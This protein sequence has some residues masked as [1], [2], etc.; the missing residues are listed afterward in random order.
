LQKPETFDPLKIGRYTVIHVWYEYPGELRS[1]AKYFIVLRHSQTSKGFICRCIKATCRVSRYES[2][3]DLLKGVVLYEEKT[4]PF[5]SEKTVIDPD[6][7]LD[8]NHAHLSD[9]S[10]KNRFRI[11]GKMPDDFHAKLVTAINQSEQLE[12]K[13]KRDLL[14][15]IGEASTS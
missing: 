7:G 1:E 12:P 6:N 3:P 15:Y 5:F 10:R 11:A 14:D 8:I 4:I 9:Q 13:K 2:D